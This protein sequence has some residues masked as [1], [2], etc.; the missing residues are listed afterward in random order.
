MPNHAD[1]LIRLRYYDFTIKPELVLFTCGLSPGLRTGSEQWNKIL[2]IYFFKKLKVLW[3]NWVYQTKSVEN[4]AWNI[5]NSMKSE[6]NDKSCGNQYLEKF[7]QTGMGI[8]IKMCGKHNLEYLQFLEIWKYDKSCG[9]QYIEN[10]C[11]KEMG[12]SIK[13]CGKQNLK[14]LQFLEIW[15]R[16]SLAE[17]N[18][19]NF[20]LVW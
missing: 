15:K 6:K 7:C 12:I 10:I 19:K 8:S 17:T 4:I 5:C 14:Y 3:Q 1:D 18:T 13:K 2:T 11:L 20:F 16:T 9:N